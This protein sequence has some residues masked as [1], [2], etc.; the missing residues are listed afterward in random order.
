MKPSVS[1]EIR[2]QV[3]E[4]RRRHSLSEVAKLAG[5]PVGTVKTICSRSGMFRDNEAHRA[6]FSLPPIKESNQTLP[7][8]PE[9][10]PQ[11]TVTGDNEIDAVLWLREV[12]CTGQAP[13]IEKAME[14]AKAIKTP[15]DQVEKRYQAWLIQTNPG[16]LFAALASFNF[17]DLKGLAKSSVDKLARQQ[18]A[19]SRLGDDVFAEIPPESFCI[20][21]LYGIDPDNMGFY[22][23]ANVDERFRVHS[24]LMPQTLG[25]CLYEIAF[26]RELY[27]L[28]N[29]FDGCGD[30]L[31]EVY[32]REQFVFR[33][34]GEIR[35]RSKEESVTVMRWMLEDKN[36][37]DRSETEAI[38]LNLIG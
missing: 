33:C 5:L 26:W 1:S 30:S 2:Q 35:P 16:S 7:A 28:R 22:D 12:I 27:Y 6:F 21:A 25:D 37:F 13:L 32:A 29:A 10:P 11:R 38:L 15:L 18:E 17:A 20:S 4:L 24:E 8:V 23:D 3:V 14:A 19:R 31:H 34:L 9:L 36:N